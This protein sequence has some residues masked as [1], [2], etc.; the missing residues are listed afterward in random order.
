LTALDNNGCL[1]IDVGSKE[2][3]KQ[4]IL[5]EEKRRCDSHK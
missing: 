5:N 2:E 1:P 4:L 3:I